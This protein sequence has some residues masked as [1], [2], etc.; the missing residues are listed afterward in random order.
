MTSENTPPSDR[1]RLEG[2]LRRLENDLQDVSVVD[3]SCVDRGMQPVVIPKPSPA[4][5]ASSRG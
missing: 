4:W 5:S 3:R 2:W 1:R